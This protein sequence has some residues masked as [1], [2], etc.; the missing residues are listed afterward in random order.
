MIKR[1]KITLIISSLVTLIPMI[2]GL[3][4]W[5][6][7]P[8]RMAIHWS[9][10]GEADGYSSALFAVLS[11]PLIMLALQWI[12]VAVS[13]FVEKRNGEQTKKAE[14]LVL[15]II[16]FL[17]VY[18]NGIVYA[19][20]FGYKLNMS[21]LVGVLLGVMFAVI[22]NYL[23]KFSRSTTMG[24]K[25][26]WA[27]CNDENWN[28]THRFGGRVWV[29][30][31]LCL[32]LI[33]FLPTKIFTVA[34]LLTVILMILLPVI[35]SYLYSR[36]Q[37]KE[38][39]ATSEDFTFEKTGMNTRGNKIALVGT[40]VIVTIILVGCAVL[41]FTG[42]IKVNYHGDAFT[43]EATYYEDITVS[44]AD[45][46]SVEYRE[47]GVDGT[48]VMGF[49]SARLML[50]NFQNDEFGNYTR[51]TYTSCDSCVVIIVGGKALV[52]NRPDE[53]Q[54]RAIYEELVAR[55]TRNGG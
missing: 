35:Y 53:A 30:G 8:E 6:I 12:L 20:A 1:N 55:T 37:I 5:D 41:M 39:R 45:I 28:A 9:I 2:F 19:T 48:R 24:I 34:A 42:N 27:L 51:Y 50:G 10:S 21:M 47:G 49:G 18:C 16:P 52:L 11:L 40:V 31:G 3:I 32:L 17:S 26:R 43:V 15:W 38:G 7:L 33:A 22:G 54:T 36:R 23:P 46:E 29:V 25:I 13:C 4:F 14:R 44:Y